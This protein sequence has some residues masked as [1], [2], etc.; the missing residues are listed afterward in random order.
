MEATQFPNLFPLCEGPTNAPHFCSSHSF[1]FSVPLFVQASPLPTPTWKS[2]LF[3]E[4][5]AG[6]YFKP[7]AVSRLIGG[8]LVAAFAPNAACISSRCVALNGRT[9]H[10]LVV[11][12]SFLCVFSCPVQGNGVQ[13]LYGADNLLLFPL[14]KDLIF[15]LAAI[16][17][18]LSC[19]PPSF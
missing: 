15:L 19:L 17:C 5:L 10:L 8:P 13:T 11:T 16:S 6:V 1:T 18:A 7:P 12:C 14:V 4:Y 3:S 9:R 2:A